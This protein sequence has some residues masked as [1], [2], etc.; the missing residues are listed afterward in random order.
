VLPPA[1][2]SETAAYYFP[3]PSLVRR[4]AVQPTR[5]RI[6]KEKV[7]H[8]LMEIDIGDAHGGGGVAAWRRRRRRGGTRPAS[9]PGG[10]ARGRSGRSGAGTAAVPAAVTGP[11]SARP[12]RRRRGCGGRGRLR[13]R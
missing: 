12:G 9:A 10:A 7:A 8:F 4:T 2:L 3:E 5:W 11:G 1:P 6:Q 13:V